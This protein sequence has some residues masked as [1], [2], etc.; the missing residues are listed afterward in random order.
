MGGPLKEVE[1][2]HVSFPLAMTGPAVGYVTNAVSNH[3]L[4]D[5]DHEWWTDTN[6]QIEGRDLLSGIALE[7]LN[8]NKKS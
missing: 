5:V 7:K 4:Y 8:S 1:Y 2:W 6:L 3:K